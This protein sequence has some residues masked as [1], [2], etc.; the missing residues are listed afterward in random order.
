MKAFTLE[1]L[2]NCSGQEGKPVYL[3]YQGKVY[4]VTKSAYWEGGRHMGTHDAGKDLTPSFPNA[5]H[6]EEV[7]EKYP[8]VGVLKEK[9]VAPAV[10]MS[11]FKRL[12]IDLH[13][14]PIS[15]HF[16]IALS[17]FSALF[18][19]LHLLLSNYSFENTGYYLMGAAALM[20]PGA[21]FT[22]L[23]SWKI[24]YNLSGRPIFVAKILGSIYLFVV[25]WAVFIWRTM[26]PNIIATRDVS[27]LLYLL[28]LFSLSPAVL[29]LGFFGGKI[30]HPSSRTL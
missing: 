12:Y 14:H 26:E 19:A 11:L 25:S 29:I 30:T 10:G 20:T 15:V 13:P 1:E 28:M 21:L 17:I 2:E 18:T 5:P 24:L 27:S 3:A 9:D 6:G 23:L 7:F 4:D 16:P 22:G 8:Q